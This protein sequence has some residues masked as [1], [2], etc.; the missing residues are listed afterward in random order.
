MSID[1]KQRFSDRVENYIR[2]RPGYPDSVVDYFEQSLGLTTEHLIADIG[3]GPGQSALPFL[4]RGYS[5]VGVEPNL[6][7]REAGVELLSSYPYRAVDGAAE[8]TTLPDNSV[9]F[10]LAGQAFHWFDIDL[11]RPE[12]Q[13][14]MKPGAWMVIMWNTRREDLPH[15]LDYELF[16]QSYSSDYLE[17][18]GRTQSEEVLRNF[19]SLGTFRK[20]SFVNQQELDFDGLKGRY[21]SCSYA[22]NE[23]HPRMPE[24]LDVLK[25]LFDRYAEEGYFRLGYYTQL[26]L[27]KLS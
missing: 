22:Y 23:G 18:K 26:Y 13:R 7:M 19:F 20:E 11:V 8:A 27:G 25:A 17:I 14:I 6:E 10:I 9:D 1:P 2:F 24:T 21:L 4:K 15:L 12:F 3:V 5:V 16:L